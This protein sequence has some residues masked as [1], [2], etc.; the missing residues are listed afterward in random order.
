MAAPETNRAPS[1]FSGPDGPSESDLY[2]CVHCG[3][4]LEVCP[5]YRVTSLETE[6]PRGRI[7]LMKAVNEGR[8][9]ITPTVVQHWDR[10]IQCRA[11]EVACPSGVPYGQLIEATKVQLESRRKESLLR[12]TVTDIS[13]KSVLPNQGRLAALVGAARFYQRSG[14]QKFVRGSRFLS[15]FSPRLAELESSL[16]NLPSTTF[17]AR[18]Q[19]I[20]AIGEQRAR[21]ALLSGCVMPLVNGPQMDAVVRVLTRNGCEVVVPKDQVCCGAIHSHTGEIEIARDL[22]RR[23][24]DVFLGAG[25]DAVVLASA[26]CGARMKEYGHLLEDDP[27]YADKARQLSQM[28]KDIHEYLVDLPLLPP[29]APL[30]YTVTYQDSCHLSNGQRITKQP[31]TVLQSIPGIRFTELPNAS[32]CCGSGG[33]YTITERELSLKVLAKKMEAVKVMGVQ[34]LAT[35]NPGCLLQLQYGVQ[36]EELPI[37]VRYVTDLL[38]EAYRLEDGTQPV[39]RP[40]FIPSHLAGPYAENRSMQMSDKKKV[41]ITGAAG[42]IG[43]VLFQTL[44][45]RYDIKGTDRV[46]APGI[47]STTAELTDLEA[48]R[49]VFQGVD[50]VVHLAAEPRHTPEIGWDLLMPN[51]VVATANVFEAARQGG[52]KRVIFFSSM[53][54][55]GLYERDEPYSAIAEGN[56]QGLVPDQV[57]LVSHEMPV[58]P[59]AQYAVSKI[60]GETLGR[61]YAEEC[62]MVV[63]CVRLG[64]VSKDD[65]PGTDARSYVSW[66]SHRDLTSMVKR[67]IDVEGITYDIFFGASGNTWKIYDTP[68]AWRVLGYQ[69]QD[70]AE[71]YRR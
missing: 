63:I 52:A 66:L 54:V 65:R 30:D 33:S 13:L 29:T 47:D 6:S 22:A 10:C 8:I 19:V 36:K 53:H 26:G 56:Y 34:V 7:A 49:P 70:N 11:C 20:P 9:D 28:V 61:Y 2:K 14:L 27:A 41:L 43:T 4:C 59:D 16:P 58:R 24:I 17:K 5:T 31:R 42:S 23:N 64:T 18:G 25:V 69:P 44:G 45:D 35:A 62:G 12:R 68:R 55:N 48:I 21:V 40:L 50:A 71:S 57:P 3:F 67:C 37:Q 32:I 46:P 60:F 51:N 15:L 38:D 1:S 39:F